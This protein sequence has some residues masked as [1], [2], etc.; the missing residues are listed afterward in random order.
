MS[1][2][3]KWFKSRVWVVTFE[4]QR[5]FSKKLFSATKISLLNVTRLGKKYFKYWHWTKRLQRPLACIKKGKKPVLLLFYCNVIS[6]SN[7][8]HSRI[9]NNNMG[10]RC[11]RVLLVKKRDIDVVNDFMQIDVLVVTEIVAS[12]LRCRMTLGKFVGKIKKIQSVCFIDYACILL[13]IILHLYD[14]STWTVSW[15]K[16]FMTS[17]HVKC[18]SFFSK[19]LFAVLFSVRHHTPPFVSWY[20]CFDL[21]H[22][23]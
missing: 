18:F 7:I 22:I 21:L 4:I 3:S 5:N 9:F 12:R 23:S 1:T 20:F 2:A 15:R 11:K 14:Q 19:N 17:L 16:I 13:L 8:E 10:I 6:H